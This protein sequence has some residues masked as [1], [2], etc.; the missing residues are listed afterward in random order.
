MKTKYNKTQ[1]NV[2]Q[3]M[4]KHIFHRDRFAHYLRWSHVLKLISTWKSGARIMDVGCGSANLLELLYRNRRA[5]EIYCGVDIKLKTLTDAHEMWKETNVNAEFY[6]VDFCEE[7]LLES[8]G[9]DRGWDLI[10]CFEVAEHIGKKNVHKLLSNIAGCC[11]DETIVLISTPVYDP[12]VGAANNHIID[13]E[14]G[15]LTFTEMKEELEKKF[16]INKVYGTFASIKDYETH[17]TDAQREVW[18]A[19]REYYD[20]NVLSVLMAPLHPE[21]SRNCIWNCQLKR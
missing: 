4:Q 8:T 21:R 15:E 17:L 12:A 1:L 3:E 6:Q 13:G 20:V 9:I 11:N 18:L 14:V 10:T 2:D 16:M 5:P 19:L 7:D